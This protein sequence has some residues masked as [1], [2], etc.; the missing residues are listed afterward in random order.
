M[1]P[2][3]QFFDSHCHI[4]FSEFDGNREVLLQQALNSGIN[5]MLVPGITLEQSKHLLGSQLAKLKLPQLYYA[6]GLHPYFLSEHQTDHIEALEQL[7]ILNRDKVVAIGECGIDSSI[8]DIEK[9]KQIFIAHI[10]LANKYQLSLIVHHR[11]SH[12]LI[13][14]AFKQNQPKFGG[15]IHAFSGSLQQAKT[16]IKM[17]FKIGV[18]G[19]IT[20]QRAKKTRNTISQLPLKSL[21]LE[22]DAPSMPISGMQGEINTPIALITIF[23]QLASLRDENKDEIAKQL[24]KNSLS[25]F[26]LN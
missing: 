8:S 1:M 9:Q 20:Y 19:V 10:H 5:K 13:A 25:T 6:I 24:Y 12:H 15:V 23:E 26:N 16:Y 17:G 2:E 11:Q 3:D 7:Y 14:Q 4:D 22:T 18:G 21:L